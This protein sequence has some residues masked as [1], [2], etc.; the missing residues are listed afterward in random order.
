MKIFTDIDYKN[1]RK[2]NKLNLKDRESLI[3][4]VNH[5]NKNQ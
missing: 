4:F 3:A 1:Y 2:K 5:L